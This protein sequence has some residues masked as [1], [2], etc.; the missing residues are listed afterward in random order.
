MREGKKKEA[1]A[2]KG[3]LA[4]AGEGRGADALHAKLLAANH[5]AGTTH[6]STTL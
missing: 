6:C 5:Q 3:A 1:E 4:A 2:M